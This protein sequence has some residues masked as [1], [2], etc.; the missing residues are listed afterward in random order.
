MIESEEE[1]TT[2][3]KLLMQLKLSLCS[4][5]NNQSAENKAYERNENTC[6]SLPTPCCLGLFGSGE[7]M[8][9]LTLS[10]IG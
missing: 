9:P 10:G 5:R 3:Q 4:F 2:K 8:K 1:Y 6:S 7:N